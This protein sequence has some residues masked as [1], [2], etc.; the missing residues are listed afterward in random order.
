MRNSEDTFKENGDLKRTIINDLYKYDHPDYRDFFVS[1]HGKD[2]DNV[3]NPSFSNDPF[4]F[5]KSKF[6][7]K[8]SKKHFDW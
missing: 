3:K 1:V 2:L 7:R 5:H 8:N 4:L 6:I